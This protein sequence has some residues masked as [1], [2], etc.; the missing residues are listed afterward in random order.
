MD[1]QDLDA[2]LESGDVDAMAAMFENA[3]GETLLDVATGEV[4]EASID[5]GID[6]TGKTDVEEEPQEEPK[7]DDDPKEAPQE[8]EEPQ[9]ASSTEPE[10]ETTSTPDGILTKD[11]KNVIPYDVLNSTRSQLTDTKGRLSEA[12]QKAADLEKELDAYKNAAKQNNLE[13]Q[14]DP[15]K[16]NEERLE[17]LK[18]EYGDELGQ[19]LFDQQQQIHQLT[20]AQSPQVDPVQAQV[21]AAIA[22]NSELS[23]WKPVYDKEGKMIGGD[24]DRWDMAASIDEKLRADESWN[25]KSFA[26]RF[27]HVAQEVNKAFGT[28]AEET[29]Q[30]LT[31]QAKAKIADAKKP[32]PDSLSDIGTPDSTS[33]KPLAVRLAEM[34]TNDLVDSM[35][36][37]TDAQMEA[38]LASADF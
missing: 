32:V 22:N 31:E 9:P 36:N 10:E 23:G 37:M 28:Q 38:L 6:D 13:V 34:E 20:Q 19:M 21:E 2:I 24:L 30:A 12:E 11:G 15:E 16:F 26:E 7:T 4:E 35:E 5:L 33:E 25:G 18:N 29:K 17:A 27:N 3:D 14:T 8:E 1:D